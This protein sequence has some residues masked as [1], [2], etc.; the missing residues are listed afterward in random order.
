MKLLRPGTAVNGR[1]R[2]RRKAR[3]S[4]LGEDPAGHRVVVDGRPQ[5]TVWVRVEGTLTGRGAG[6]LAADLRRALKRRKDRVVLDLARLTEVKN[7][8]AS[9][10]VEGLRGYRDRIRIVLPKVGEMAALATFF[11]LYR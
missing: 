7:G 10:I 5:S 1:P 4:L 11:G 3:R 9:S 2:K 8:A 6:N